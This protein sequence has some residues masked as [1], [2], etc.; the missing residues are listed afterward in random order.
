MRTTLNLDPDV[1]ERLGELAKARGTSLSRV[2][3]DLVRAG[4]RSEMASTKA[5]PYEPPVLRTGRVRID[6]TDVAE[7]L[8]QL[9]DG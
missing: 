9:E 3:N 5:G 1:A 2:A 8:E 4:L 7:A 6:V